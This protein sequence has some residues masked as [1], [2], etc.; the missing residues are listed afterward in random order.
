MANEDSLLIMADVRAE[1][2]R[3]D[4]DLVDLLARRAACIDRAIAIKRRAALPARIESRVDDVLRRTRVAG[5]ARGLDPEF[6]EGL[7]RHIIEWSIGR[8][9]RALGGTGEQGGGR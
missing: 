4:A 6:V 3:I 1:I 8:E 2:D 9:E 7:W 5:A